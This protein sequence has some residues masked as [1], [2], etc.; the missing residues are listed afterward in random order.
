MTSNH[1]N[2]PLP[3]HSTDMVSMKIAK[4][5]EEALF[6][7]AF[8]REQFDVRRCHTSHTGISYRAEAHCPPCA[9]GKTFTIDAHSTFD[10]F[11]FG[12]RYM[13][14]VIAAHCESPW[15]FRAVES[16][17]SEIEKDNRLLVI[18][19]RN[20]QTNAYYSEV[21]DALAVDANAYELIPLQHTHME[22]NRTYLARFFPPQHPVFEHF[23]EAFY[24]VP[25]SKITQAATC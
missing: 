19:S 24:Y 16:D 11:A 20:G 1:P 6:F 10:F 14:K 21:A 5:G 18:K 8:L 9:T 15:I 7:E 23:G 17:F 4:Y 12:M 22:D 3:K 2:S 13:R 25:S